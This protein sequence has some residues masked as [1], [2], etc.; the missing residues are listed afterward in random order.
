MDLPVI[1]RYCGEIPLDMSAV[2]RQ[3][4]P[5][6]PILVLYC[7]ERTTAERL[8]QDNAAKRHQNVLSMH[9][10]GTGQAEEKRA[11]KLLTQARNQV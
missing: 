10:S 11:R 1:H 4:G 7:T 3:T 8:V 6:T 9:L 2:L 5:A